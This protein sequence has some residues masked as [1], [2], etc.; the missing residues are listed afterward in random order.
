[1]LHCFFNHLCIVCAVTVPVFPLCTSSTLARTV[2]HHVANL[3]L[4][5]CT[6]VQQGH[7]QRISSAWRAVVSQLHLSGTWLCSLGV[8]VRCCAGRGWKMFIVACVLIVRIVCRSCRSD[9]TFLTVCNLSVFA[10]LPWLNLNLGGTSG[11]LRF[12]CA[13]GPGCHQYQR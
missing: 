12:V 9:R 1:M 13:Y 11:C 10:S 3:M 7:G 2:Q 4:W 6:T 5:M 8:T